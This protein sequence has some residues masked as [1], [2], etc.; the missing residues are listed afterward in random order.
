M[1]LLSCGHGHNLWLMNE[2][3]EQVQQIE[4]NDPIEARR[5]RYAQYRGLV[6]TLTF[7]G[8]TV[9]GIVRAVKQDRSCTPVRWSIT[10]A[11][12]Q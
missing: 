4:T 12:Q 9:K 3:A 11:P 10:I 2:L 7:G 6:A 1:L 5:S 8:S